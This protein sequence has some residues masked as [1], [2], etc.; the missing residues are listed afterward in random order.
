MQRISYYI[1]NFCLLLFVSSCS[2]SEGPT[3]YSAVTL[4][5]SGY[6]NLKENTVTLRGQ[7]THLNGVPVID[8]GFVIKKMGIYNQS[9]EEKEISLGNKVGEG[10]VSTNYTHEKIFELDDVYSFC[11][12]VKTENGYYRSEFSQFVIDGIDIEAQLD[13]QAY[14][15]E[16]IVI[17]GNFKN[18][19]DAHAL[20]A[21]ASYISQDKIPY[22]VAPDGTSIT[23]T[24]PDKQH[25]THGRKVSFRL[26]NVDIN[27]NEVLREIAIVKILGTLNPPTQ[28][29]YYLSDPIM[30]TG[31]ALSTDYWDLDEPLYLLIDGKKVVYNPYIYIYNITGLKGNKFSLGYYNG[32]D[33]VIFKDPIELIVPDGNGIV[34]ERKAVHPYSRLRVGGLFTYRDVMKPSE[35]SFQLGGQPIGFYDSNGSNSVTFNLQNIPEGNQYFECKNEFYSIKSSQTIEVRNLSWSNFD[36][37]NVYQGEKV[38]VAGNFINGVTYAIEGKDFNLFQVASE[39]SLEFTIPA[40]LTG[41]QPIEIGYPNATGGTYLA[42]HKRSIYVEQFKID[43]IYPTKGYAG[44]L[45]SI[46]GKGLLGVYVLFGGFHAN[47]VY[48]STDEIRVMIPSSFNK[49]KVSL[50]FMADGRTIQGNEQI[51]IL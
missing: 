14:V 26:R 23:F 37:T 45:I 7:I 5:T 17:N 30:L 4:A 48:S 19:S 36:R 42:K 21:Y 34:F 50:V 32:R 51:E 28:K 47:I 29:S 41:E 27:G 16:N 22:R 25:Y 12:Y 46:K 44:D 33:S 11:L 38:K 18:L 2:K 31:T 3:D 8:H 43:E 15:N 13:L 10:S 1:I 6:S 9:G 35:A 49:G 24:L 39:G 20:F 40:Y